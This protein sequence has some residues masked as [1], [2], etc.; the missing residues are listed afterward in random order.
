M[1]EA[2]SMTLPKIF[3]AEIKHLP[4]KRVF[5]IA[6]SLLVMIIGFPVFFLVALIVGLT[7]R[8]NLIYSHLRVGRGGVLFKCYKFR[9]MYKDADVRLKA[10]LAACPN[11]QKE[12]KEKYKLKNDPRITPI[13]N[14]LRKTSLDELPQ[15]WNVLKGDLSIVGP[16]PVVEEEIHQYFGEKAQ[17]ILSIRPG[18][19]GLWQIYGRSNTSYDKRIKLDEEYVDHQS[20]PLDIKLILKTIPVMIC[21]RGAY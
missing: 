4:L 21:R 10:I 2:E 7:S 8:G 3:N 16:R 14:F 9:T 17:K 15:F 19:T 5:D 12:W 20:L 6:F 18:L 13:G 1:E 11:K